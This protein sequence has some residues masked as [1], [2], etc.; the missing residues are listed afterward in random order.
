MF[1]SFKAHLEDDVLQALESICCTSKAQPVDV[2]LYW[3]I[4]G[5]VRGLWEE[6][7]TSNMAQGPVSEAP[8]L[9]KD[10]MVD[11]IIRAHALLDSQP[12]C[13]AKSFKVCGISNNL[14]GFENALVHCAKELP[15]FTI[16]YG[17]DNSDEDIFNSDSDS[18]SDSDD[19]NENEMTKMT[20]NLPLAC[21]FT[22]N[23][24]IVPNFQGAQF[25]RIGLPRFC[26]NNFCR[27]EPSDLY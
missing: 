22:H 12:Q 20:K 16:P 11:W 15:A 1:D 17:N 13:V 3:P 9:T 14:D 27:S 24:R 4:K 2:S 7:M 26:G 8:A 6:F 23:Y 25:L 19:E 10:D 18:T 5:A 21:T